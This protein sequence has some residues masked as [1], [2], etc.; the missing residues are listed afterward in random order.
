MVSSR[1]HHRALRLDLDACACMPF[2]E[3]K[4]CCPMDHEGPR[5]ESNSLIVDATRCYAITIASMIWNEVQMQIQQ[6][7]W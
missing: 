2:I 5:W 1:E 4:G 6:I 7:I 3:V